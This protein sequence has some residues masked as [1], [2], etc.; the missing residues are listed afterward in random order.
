[1]HV[2]ATIQFACG[3][4][5]VSELTSVDARP[6]NLVDGRGVLK[7]VRDPDWDIICVWPCSHVSSGFIWAVFSDKVED[8]SLDRLAPFSLG[9]TRLG[10]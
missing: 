7:A 1:M 10:A 8:A 9:R 5:G 6:S 3:F 4:L 2:R